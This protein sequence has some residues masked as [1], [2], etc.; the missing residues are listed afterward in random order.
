MKNAAF[1]FITIAILYAI[2]G[3]TFGIGMGMK[4]DFTYADVHA[5][6]NLVGWVT[7]TLFGLIYRSYPQMAESRLTAVHFWVANAG[8]LAMTTGIFFVIKMQFMPL[9]ILGALLTLTSMIIFLVNFQ[10]HRAA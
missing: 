5:H 2:T 3:M 8:A 10:R 9:V 6:I 7:L 1:W 4:G